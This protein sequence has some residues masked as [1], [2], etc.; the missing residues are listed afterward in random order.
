MALK[1]ECSPE[2]T[3]KPR[4]FAIPTTAAKC[5]WWMGGNLVASIFYDVLS[6]SFPLGELFAPDGI[7]GWSTWMKWL[8]F[9]FARPGL[10]RRVTGSYLLCC[11]PGFHPWRVYD[12]GLTAAADSEFQA[13]YA[14]S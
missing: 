4:D 7:R 1:T 9:A 14:R 6:S 10:L 5:R 2:L 13:S 3:I 11:F 12:R 8:H